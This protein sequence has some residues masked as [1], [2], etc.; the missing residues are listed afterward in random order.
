MKKNKKI[1][2]IKDLKKTMK[3]QYKVDRKRKRDKYKCNKCHLNCK[4]NLKG[5][6]MSKTCN[7]N[8]RQDN[9]RINNK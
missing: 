6:N 7:K 5:A 8:N 9:K 3:Y 4:I 2:T 1:K